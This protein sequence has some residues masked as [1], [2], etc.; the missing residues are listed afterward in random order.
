MNKIP[1]KFIFMKVGQHAGEEFDEILARKREEVR[2]AGMSFWGYGG[3]TC[4]PTK[5]VRPFVKDVVANKGHVH[6]LMEPMDSKADPDLVPA[7]EYSEDGVLWKPIPKGIRVTGSRYAVV[8]GEIKAE[9][10]EL[11]LDECIVGLGLSQGKP[12]SDY[13]QGRVDKACLTF[14]R[15]AAKRASKHRVASI[16]YA[17]EIIDPFAV[18]LRGEE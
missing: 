5:Q 1:D 14:D 9:E 6:L 16:K 12:A 11:P 8:L 7:T 3:P 10:I 13:I 17:A 2:K 4:H 15:S 18:L